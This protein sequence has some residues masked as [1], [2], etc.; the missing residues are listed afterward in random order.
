MVNGRYIDLV[1]DPWLNRANGHNPTPIKEGLEGLK[2]NCL[3]D[4]NNSWM[5]RKI[6]EFF[7][8]GDANDILNI[9]LGNPSSKD[10]IVWHPD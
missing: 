5:E 4:D 8:Q 6:R 3:L 7:N 9:P 2:V 10:E 1:K